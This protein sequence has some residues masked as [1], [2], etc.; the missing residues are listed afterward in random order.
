MQAPTTKFSIAR[1]A[2]EQGISFYRH[3]PGVRT[4][5]S[6]MVGFHLDLRSKVMSFRR[7]IAGFRR[8][9]AK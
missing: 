5:G 8:R 9:C 7:D 4:M 1:M 3:C 2:V 6:T